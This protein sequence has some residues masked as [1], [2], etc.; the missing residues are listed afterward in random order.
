M[1]ERHENRCDEPKPK[2]TLIYDRSSFGLLKIKYHG[3]TI[4]VSLHQRH[5]KILVFLNRALDEDEDL[6][7]EFR[8]LRTNAKIAE[9][10][11]EGDQFGYTPSGNAIAAYRSQIHR[12]IRD[13]SPNGF[14]HR[15]MRTVRGAGVRLIDSIEVIELSR[16]AGQ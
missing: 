1:I 11:T 6:D 10:Y 5:V 15:L 16:R 9:S 12:R 8:G 3:L 2:I 13:A 4:K 14:P 7:E